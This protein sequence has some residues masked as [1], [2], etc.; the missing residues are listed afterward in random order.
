MLFVLFINDLPKVIPVRSEA[1]LYAD[2]TKIYQQISCEDN[3]QHLQQTLTNLATWSAT[4]NIKFNEGKCKVLT[5]SCKKEPIT[6]PYQLGYTTISRVQKEKDLGITISS[7]LSWGLHIHAITAKANKLLRLLRRTCPF[8]TETRVRCTLYLTIVKSQLCY[9]SKVWSPHINAQKLHL[10][11]VQR[12]A[13]RWILRVRKGELGYRERLLKLN[14]LLLCY[15]HEI[16]DLLFFYKALYG[17]TNINVHEH[18][19]FVTHNP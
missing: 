18:V 15:G 10:E 1:A 4:N 7:D 13:T 14:L 19:S 6:C 16:N 17:L 11:Q 3:A 5:V 8:L 2:D 9:A 12:Y